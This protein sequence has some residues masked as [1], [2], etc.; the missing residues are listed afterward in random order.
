M[1]GTYQPPAS[2]SPHHILIH[3]VRW[4]I[5]AS[6]YTYGSGVGFKLTFDAAIVIFVMVSCDGMN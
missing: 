2:I 5:V 6:G 3:D 1:V 4:E